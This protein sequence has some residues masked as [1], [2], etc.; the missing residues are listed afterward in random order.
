[1]TFIHIIRHKVFLGFTPQPDNLKPAKFPKDSA[2]AKPLFIL[3]FP[4]NA[5]IDFMSSVYE[6]VELKSL[7]EN[8]LFLNFRQEFIC[9]LQCFKDF[10]DGNF[11]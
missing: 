1:L 2:S 9:C 11:Q 6:S 5:G 7:T 8:N 3:A 10:P 4:E